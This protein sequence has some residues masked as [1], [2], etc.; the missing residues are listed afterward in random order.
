MSHPREIFESVYQIKSRIIQ[1]SLNTISAD[2]VNVEAVLET[3]S[4]RK[5]SA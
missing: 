3:S 5:L 2:Y 1:S 4:R